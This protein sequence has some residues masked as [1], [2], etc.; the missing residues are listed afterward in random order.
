MQL[1]KNTRLGNSVEALQKQFMDFEQRTME[2]NQQQQLMMQQQIQQQAL[3]YQQ[4]LAN[5]TQQQQQNTQLLL[6]VIE[7]ITKSYVGTIV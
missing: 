1:E 5:Q 4:L 7:K 3:Q 2:Q 6:S